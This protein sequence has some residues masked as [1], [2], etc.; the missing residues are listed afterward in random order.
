MTPL[1]II[2]PEPGAGATAAR[3]RAIGIE[4]RTFPLF[5]IVSVTWSAPQPDDFDALVLT[6]ANAIRHG[7]PQLDLLKGLPVHAVGQATAAAART[8]G[9]TVESS[10]E[11]GA[12]AMSLPRGRRLLHLAGRDH[13][14]IG[15][16][17]T[18]AV[19]E[20]REVDHRAASGVLADCVV[21]V[22]SPRAGRRLAELVSERARIAIA[23]ISPA[24]AAACG[25]GWKSVEA[26]PRPSDSALLAL[27]ARLC[28]SR[29]S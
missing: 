25:T 24:A 12:A 18:I 9:F 8:A 17:R 20:A 4:A 23:A 28:K 16:E 15:A 2:R 14:D 3:A 27:A 1:V 13:V 11:G 26:A 22:H 7:G 21:A 5:E 19:Y 6:S 10:G 29:A